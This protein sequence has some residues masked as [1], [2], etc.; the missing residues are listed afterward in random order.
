M[1]KVDETEMTVY[2]KDGNVLAVYR[3]WTF[4]DTNYST[5]SYR[6]EQIE[7]KS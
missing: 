4:K 3:V 6:F 5:F 2:D 1:K 7:P